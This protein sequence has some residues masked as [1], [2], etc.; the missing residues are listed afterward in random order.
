[1]NKFG[2]RCCVSGIDARRDLYGFTLLFPW[3]LKPRS[4]SWDIYPK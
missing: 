1:M 3:F 2:I 4:L